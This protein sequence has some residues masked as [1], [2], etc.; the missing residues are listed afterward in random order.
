MNNDEDKD[1]RR[2]DRQPTGGPLGCAA[3][4][5]LMILSAAVTVWLG[6]LAWQ[7]IKARNVGD[8]LILTGIL[9]AWPAWHAAAGA[10][11]R[12]RKRD[13][14]ARISESWLNEHRRSKP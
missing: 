1:L 7:L 6:W 9:I 13:V 8:M 14:A 3:S 12:E 4:I 10:I 5:A 2:R 11:E